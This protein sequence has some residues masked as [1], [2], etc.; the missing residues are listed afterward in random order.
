M[1]ETLTTADIYLLT[2]LLLIALPIFIS[3]YLLLPSLS[4][5]SFKE[6]Y[7][8]FLWFVIFIGG[9]IMFFTS[10]DSIKNIYSILWVVALWI[11]VVPSAI[12]IKYG[13]IHITNK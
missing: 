1:I 8:W 4:I 5:K 11:W 13:S 12:F 9:G 7:S 6:L 3:G 2:P 10:I